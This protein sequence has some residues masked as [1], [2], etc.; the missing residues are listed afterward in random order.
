MKNTPKLF[1][2]FLTVSYAIV[3]ITTNKKYIFKASAILVI[4]VNK[5]KNK[6]ILT[7][8]IPKEIATAFFL[9]HIP[10]GKR[11]FLFNVTSSFKPR[12]SFI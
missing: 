11:P 9:P 3:I 12:I 1:F 8:I 2:K 6:T 10:T 4:L 5:N 7:K